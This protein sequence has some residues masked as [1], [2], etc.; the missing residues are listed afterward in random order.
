MARFY[1]PIGFV[2]SQETFEGSGIWEDV[3][4]EKKY[5]GIIT[6]N[7]KKWDSSEY[8]NKDINISNVISIVA[9]PYIS[10]HLASIRY[11]KWLGSYWEIINVSVEH[12]RLVL[13]IGGVYNGPKV[14]TSEPTDEHPRIQ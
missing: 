12:P 14:T 11:I 8:L 6:K 10:N 1:G 13:T 5:R 9:D 4:F 2:N 7:I 3:P